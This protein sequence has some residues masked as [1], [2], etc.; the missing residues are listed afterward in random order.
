VRVRAV[1]RAAW[2]RPRLLLAAAGACAVFALLP[3]GLALSSRLLIAWDTAT[4]LYLALAWT[5]M[6][7]SDLERMRRRAAAQDEGDVAILVIIIIAA[8]ASLAAIGAELHGTGGTVQQSKAARM[9]LAGVTIF[10]SWCFMHTTFA[11]H[12]AHEFYAGTGL[13]A[14]GLEFPKKDYD[15]DYWDFLYFSF[16]IGAACQTSDVTIPGHRMRRLALGHTIL[17]FLFN[18]T[19]LALAVNVGA[20]L[21]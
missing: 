17:S 8:V 9:S 13:E 15:P 6:A 11:L 1:G 19:V 7:R 2:A 5:M 14:R 10:C 20:S 4:I 21:V 3:S 16:T 18:T 12:Y